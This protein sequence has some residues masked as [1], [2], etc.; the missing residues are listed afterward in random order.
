MD[1]YNFSSTDWIWQ[2]YLGICVT[3]LLLV[4]LYIFFDGYGF[5]RGRRRAIR[6]YENALWRAVRRRIDRH[7][8]A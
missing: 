4:L 3:A 8:A 7:P 5:R 1:Q 2:S 6:T